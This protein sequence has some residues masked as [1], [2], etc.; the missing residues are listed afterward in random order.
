MQ[1]VHTSAGGASTNGQRSAHLSTGNAALIV[2][3]GA[4]FCQEHL[5]KVACLDWVILNDLDGAIPQ[6]GHGNRHARRVP[7]LD[8]NPYTCSLRTW[9]HRQ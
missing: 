5:V 8:A 2:K 3:C 4:A 9:L 6:R 7:D 1:V